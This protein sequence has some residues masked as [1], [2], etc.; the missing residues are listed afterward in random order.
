MFGDVERAQKA[1][2]DSLILYPLIWT[3][4]IVIG[5]LFMFGVWMSPQE[6]DTRLWT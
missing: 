5:I 1:F 4:L 6:I 2:G 3:V